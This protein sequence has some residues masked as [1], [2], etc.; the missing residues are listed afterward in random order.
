MEWASLNAR[1]LCEMLKLL[2]GTACACGQEGEF[3]K[4]Q[5]CFSIFGI[6][7]TFPPRNNKKI[8]YG[9]GVLLCCWWFVLWCTF[10][11]LLNTTPDRSVL[12]GVT[13]FCLCFSERY[14]DYDRAYLF[15]DNTVFI[16]LIW[17]SVWTMCFALGTKGKEI[18]LSRLRLSS[19]VPG[20]PR[21][22]FDE[23]CLIV[24][25]IP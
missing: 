24:K 17:Q 5:I 11:T 8:A 1:Q 25:K 19:S 6:S 7:K 3:I 16:C 9:W 15:P 22:Y 13:L 12:S 21:Q 14:N 4:R 10:F 23:S 20:A 2:C 18:C